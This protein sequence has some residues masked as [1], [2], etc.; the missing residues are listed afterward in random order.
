MTGSGMPI[1]HNRAPLS[2]PISVPSIFYETGSARMTEAPRAMSRSVE[3][4]GSESELAYSSEGYLSV[5]RHRAEA[6]RRA[7]ISR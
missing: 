2:E 4:K 6:G 5:K 3:N 1:S 7:A